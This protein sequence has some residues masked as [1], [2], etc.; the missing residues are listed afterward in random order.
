MKPSLVAILLILNIQAANA[1]SLKEKVS[2]FLRPLVSEY[3]GEDKARAWFGESDEHIKMPEIPSVEKRP[4]SVDDFATADPRLAKIPADKKQKYNYIYIKE[5]FLVTRNMDGTKNEI[6][7]LMN[8]MGQGGS[9]EGIYRGLVLGQAYRGL[10]NMENPVNDSVI[11]FSLDYLPKF[12][13]S[14]VTKEK[15][16]KFNFYSL[17]RL[18]TEKTLE[19]LDELIKLDKNNNTS[20]AYDWYAIFSTDL[21]TQYPEIWQSDIRKSVSKLTQRGWAEGVP[22]EFLKSEVIVKLHK[23]FNF[24]NR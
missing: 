1:E 6:S 3:I 17:K 24:L 14:N 8:V 4:N 5:L 10:E 9:R 20:E 7:K 23:V 12:V 19:I 22:T 16:E 11:K 13:S 2:S 15:L 18:A 21:A